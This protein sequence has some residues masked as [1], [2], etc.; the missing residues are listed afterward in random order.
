MLKDVWLPASRIRGSGAF[1]R[2]QW[3]FVAFYSQDAALQIPLPW[4][5]ESLQHH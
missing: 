5:D 2:C 4:V 3:N 1:Q